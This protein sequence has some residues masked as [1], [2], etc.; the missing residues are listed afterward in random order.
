M[1]VAVLALLV[2]M[3]LATAAVSVAVHTNGLSRRD[4]NYKNALEAAEAGL[5]IGLYRLNELSPD[6]SPGSTQCVGDTL[7]NADATGWCASSAYTLGNGSTYHYY[8]TPPLLATGT[9]AGL[10]LAA[11][12]VNQR[13]VTAVGTSHGVIARSQIRT[14]AFAAQPLFQIPG[15][16]GLIGVTLS[17][18]SQV[19]GSG[20]SNVAITTSGGAAATA[21]ELGPGGK[22]N[23]QSCS[24]SATVTCLPGPI[25]AAPVNTG[26]SYLNNTNARITNG[27]ANANG[28]SPQLLPADQVSNPSGVT[29]DATHRILTL[30]GSA[31]TVTLTGS[32]YNFCQ[33]TLQG[34]SHMAVAAGVRAE[35]YIDSPDDP[36]SGVV[37]SSTNPPCQSNTGNLTLSGGS[38]F[39]NANLDPLALQLYVYGLNNGSGTITLSGGSTLYGTLYAPQSAITLSGGT[40]L[41]GGMVG[42]TVTISGGGLDWDSRDGSLQASPTGTYYRTAWAQCTP[43]Y[44]ASSP[45]SGCG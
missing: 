8:T 31:T 5:Q 22:L 29:F 18:G 4:A 2:V 42:K 36:N 26:T 41:I 33:L 27:V 17:G 43:T 13:C 12:D 35:I 1:I 16:T 44:T 6:S 3:T 10:P 9:C 15:V 37:G 24:P 19:L 21:Y 14:G 32:V 28:A 40:T 11:S 45:G 23:N 30:S 38:T 39:L 25:V 20:G 34:G 7:Q